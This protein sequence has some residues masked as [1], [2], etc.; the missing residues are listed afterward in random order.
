MLSEQFLYS[1]RFPSHP[2][3]KTMR[4]TRPPR[5]MK[6]TLEVKLGSQVD[7]YISR[8]NLGEILREDKRHVMNIIHTRNV[9]EDIA[10]LG[11]NRVLGT[12]PLNVS[13]QELGLSRRTRTY[14]TQ[15]RSGF[16]PL[17]RSY[18]K[19]IGQI[20][21]DVCL[22]CGQGP[23]DTGH[24][25]NCPTKPTDLTIESL[26]TDPVGVALFLGLDTTVGE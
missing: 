8:D 19:R 23:H 21:D 17:L 24:L 7:S 14:L 1:S 2:N 11:T 16:S 20:D 10:G 3:F 15:L 22:D 18:L 4:R 13:Q 5:I 9:T 25:F 12:E 26:W 6:N